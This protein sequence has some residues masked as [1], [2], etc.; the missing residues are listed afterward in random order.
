MQINRTA[1]WSELPLS[2][3][4]R[5]YQAIRAKS[6]SDAKFLEKALGLTKDETKEIKEVVGLR[7]LHPATT[8]QLTAFCSS[9]STPVPGLHPGFIDEATHREYIDY[10]VF[11][12][13][14]EYA[15][16][17][18]VRHAKGFLSA[19]GIT[20]H[21]LGTWM[22]S[23][24]DAFGVGGHQHV[25]SVRGRRAQPP[26]S[27][28]YT[29]PGPRAQTNSTVTRRDSRQAVR[30]QSLEAP[31]LPILSSLPLLAS[32][33]KP[34]SAQARKLA[35][36]KNIWADPARRQLPASPPQARRKINL[37]AGEKSLPQLLQAAR[38][39]IAPVP[40]NT[41]AREDPVPILEAHGVL[42]EVCSADSADLQARSNPGESGAPTSPQAAGHAESTGDK[43][44][45]VEC[46]QMGSAPQPLPPSQRLVLKVQENTGLAQ[47]FRKPP[48]Q[49][50]PNS[51]TTAAPSS[52]VQP[53]ASIARLSAPADAPLKRKASQ[54]D[55]RPEA[56]KAPRLVTDNLPAIPQ[57]AFVSEPPPSEKPIPSKPK[58]PHT[59]APGQVQS[60][61]ATSPIAPP[62]S[63]IS[64]NADLPDFQALLEPVKGRVKGPK[65][66]KLTVGKKSRAAAQREE[67]AA[68]AA[69]AVGLLSGRRK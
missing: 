25:S 15:S 66:L 41:T 67:E 34:G 39:L 16:E 46:V 55:L 9:I 13:K 19:R 61:A 2:L 65:K 24:T 6:P 33:Y 44:K 5:I 4:Y 18:Q 42:Y 31:P 59:T 50:A 54:P 10:M 20:Y 28:P 14:H 3:Q 62:I 12:S 63:P 40:K 26:Q 68:L 48:P 32:H 37:Q 56:N 43:G 38:Q 8:E 60:S 11:A 69:R 17:A 58:D 21:I 22:P 27:L 23:D 53:A 36:M 35:E 7:A 47:V 30:E 52:P 51:L 29:L 49:S 57:Y 45:G 64:E 1:E